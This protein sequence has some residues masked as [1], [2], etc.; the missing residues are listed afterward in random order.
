VRDCEVAACFN[1]VF[2]DEDTV[3]IGGASEPLYVPASEGQPAR[4]FYREDFAASALHEAAH[5]CI[6]GSGRRGQV[7][8]GYVYVPPPRDA[9]A[10]HQFFAAEIRTQALESL[11]AQAAG[12]KFRASADNLEVS[13]DVFAQQIAIARPDMH[14]WC[15]DSA[16]CRAR[17]FLA[18][19]QHAAIGCGGDQCGAG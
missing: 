8:F 16:D 2:A 14:R 4:L 19:L 5:W 3:M 7:D 15:M 18:A 1:R 11:F 13:P 17:R 6:A 10:Q 12:V 9:Q